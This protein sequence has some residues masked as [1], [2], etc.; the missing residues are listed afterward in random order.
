MFSED[1]VEETFD[2]G[3]A[4]G[5]CDWHWHKGD[6]PIVK[7]VDGVCPLADD[8]HESMAMYDPPG[9]TRID[10]IR[11]NLGT[12]DNQCPVCVYD[13]VSLYLYSGD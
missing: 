10:Y 9:A 13:P 7:L 12:C 6:P 1:I 8:H 4:P 3:P 2:P 11:H 5:E